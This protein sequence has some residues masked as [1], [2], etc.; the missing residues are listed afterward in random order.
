MTTVEES[1]EESVV[2]PSSANAIEIGNHRNALEV[3]TL[4]VGAGAG[5]WAGEGVSDGSVVEVS[6]GVVEVVG[7]VGAVDAVDEGV[8]IGTV[9]EGV[10]T[11]EDT[12]DDAS[13]VDDA[14]PERIS[15]VLASLVEE[16]T[17]VDEAVSVDEAF[18]EE[19]LGAVITY[20]ERAWSPICHTSVSPT[21]LMSPEASSF[22]GTK[23]PQSI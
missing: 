7:V 23:P 5:T 14:L 6:T 16:V 17:S 12:L 21:F 2:V 15:V 9:D 11:D 13:E 18:V 8:A 19:A 4:S 10:A 1:V 20:C 22:G 3:A